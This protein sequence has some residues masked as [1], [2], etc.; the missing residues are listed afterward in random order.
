MGKIKKARS[1]SG[2]VQTSKKIRLD[3]NQTE[4]REV[5]QYCVATQSIAFY[6]FF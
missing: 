1:R 6:V 4:K 2:T 3:E 5:C